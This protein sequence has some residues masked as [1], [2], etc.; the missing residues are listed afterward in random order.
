[1]SKEPP[2]EEVSDYKTTQEQTPDLRSPELAPYWLSSIIESA[3][4]AIISKTLEGIITSWNKGA[5]RIFGYTSDEVVGKPITILIPKEL[6]SEEPVILAR[7]R[8]GERISHYE[9]VRRRKD[10]TLLNISL[11]VS[12]IRDA[13]GRIIGASKIARDITARTHSELAQAR[14]AA[15]IESAE[16]AVISKTLEGII[17]SWNKGA[18]RIFGYTSDEAVGRSVTMLI[19]DDHIDEEP[20]ILARIRSGERIEHYET[21]RRRKDGTLLDISLTVSPIRAADGRII[22]ASKIARDITGQ[23]EAQRSLDESA[24]RLSLALA[25]A[26]LGDWSWDTATDIVT[27]SETAAAIFGIPPG[28]QLTWAELRALLHE[29]DRERARKAVEDALASHSDYDIEYRVVHSGGPERW[30]SARG[31]GRYG[32][33]GRVLGMLGVVQ[34]VTERKRTVEELR[35]QTEALATINEVGQLISGELD[36]HHL[37]Q[38]VTDAATELTGARFGSFFYNV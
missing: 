14:L 9:T 13:D 1:M 21:V 18:E 38:A 30:V 31:R 16:D 35:E 23:R 11:T 36:L 19:P 34:D 25:A 4:D 8:S 5:E 17:T 10:G 37:V 20:V 7:I 26:R 32:E 6:Q 2:Q 12:P 3:E 22:G 33:D 15:I 29:D 28:S 27:L 24:T